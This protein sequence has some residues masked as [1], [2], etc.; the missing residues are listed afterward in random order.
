MPALKLC[1]MSA[2]MSTF[3]SNIQ[4]SFIVSDMGEHGERAIQEAIVALMTSKVH[5]TVGEL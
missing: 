2:A 1:K 4:R 5:D 3:V